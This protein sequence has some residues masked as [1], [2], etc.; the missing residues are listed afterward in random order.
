[1]YCQ[2]RIVLVRTLWIV[3]ATACGSYRFRGTLIEPSSTAS[4]ILLT[5]QPGQPEK[6]SDYYER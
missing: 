1:M 6:L 5:N 3:F 2:I 4:E